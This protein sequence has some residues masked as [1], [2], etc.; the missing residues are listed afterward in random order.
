M[1]RRRFPIRHNIYSRAITFLHG[2]AAEINAALKRDCPKGDEH[3]DLSSDCIGRYVIYVQNGYEADYICIVKRSNKSEMIGAL[4]HEVFHHV[5]YTLRKAGMP[6]SN[7][8][9]EA[10]C[11]YFG[12]VFRNCLEAMT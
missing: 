8:S 2:T 10:Y 5:S 7:E 11:Y 9:D 12:W 1:R 4:A 6:L 3:R